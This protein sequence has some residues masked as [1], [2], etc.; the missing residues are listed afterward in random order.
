M[1]IFLGNTNS[2]DQNNLNPLICHRDTSDYMVLK[3][4]GA[5]P[6]G[7]FA[8]ILNN[9]PVK[10][11]SKVNAVI[12]LSSYETTMSYL[13]PFLFTISFYHFDLFRY[14]DPMC[15]HNIKLKYN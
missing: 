10:K 5:T 2:G 6:S 12:I 4:F 15:Y 8:T 1:V 14:K 3:L 11:H 13:Y 9:V 7:R